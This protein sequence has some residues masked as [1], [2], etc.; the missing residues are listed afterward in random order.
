MKRK[1]LLASLVVLALGMILAACP[2]DD[3]ADD[4]P[5]PPVTINPPP[6]PDPPPAP[7]P[8]EGIEKADIGDIVGS[9]ATEADVKYSSGEEDLYAYINRITG[10]ELPE[11][12]YSEASKPMAKVSIEY[13]TL[14]L[15]VDK[16]GKLDAAIKCKLT[17]VNVKDKWGIFGFREDRWQQAIDFIK[18]AWGTPT[19]SVNYDEHTISANMVI[20]RWIDY[21]DIKELLDDNMTKSGTQITIGTEALSSLFN[22]LAFDADITFI[23]NKFAPPNPA[24]CKIPTFA[25]L[26]GEWYSE[27]GRPVETVREF[28]ERKG[29]WTSTATMLGDMGMTAEQKI[30][31]TI[32]ATGHMQRH[33][34]SKFIAIPKSDGT[35]PSLYGQFAKGVVDAWPAPCKPER[36]DTAHTISGYEEVEKDL[37]LADL[38]SG[39]TGA[40]MRITNDG[41]KLWIPGPAQRYADSQA[42]GFTPN[43]ATRFY[44]LGYPGGVFIKQ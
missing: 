6:P 33:V 17:A 37:D 44:E 12:R 29:K 41:K 4:Y 2:T 40:A 21:K 19:A 24:D 16:N 7:P 20:N 39:Q 11:D 15:I 30:T 13:D 3:P 23:S 1:F 31:L 34:E 43:V 36:D 38:T 32:N 14:S 42:Q 25:D 35:W 10:Q 27:N 9:W 28:L 26:E 18:T 8:L 5:P 22:G